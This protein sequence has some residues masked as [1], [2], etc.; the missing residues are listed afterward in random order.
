MSAPL[1]L[2]TSAWLSAL[3]GVQPYAHEIEEASARYVPG[4]VLAEMDHLLRHRRGAMHRVL[5]DV[6]DGFYAYEPPTAADLARAVEIDR[7][8]DSLGL[9]LVDSSIA[10]TAERIGVLRVL[11]RDADFVAMRVGRRFDKALDLPVVPGR[12]SR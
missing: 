3:A 9:G 1:V 5:A 10:A 8:F 12:R 7:R 2:D 4:L 11:T 6:N